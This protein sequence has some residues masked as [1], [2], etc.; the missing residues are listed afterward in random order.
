MSEPP[1]MSRWV[2]RLVLFALACAVPGAGVAGESGGTMT[3]RGRFLYTAA[4]ERVV[5]RGVNEMFAHSPDPTGQWTLPEIARTG[6]N[7][8]RIMTTPDYA[9]ETLDAVLRNAINNG[10]IPIAEC[11]AATGKWEKLGDC[12]DYW[13]RPDIAAVVRRHRRWVLVNIANEAGAEVSASAF[14]AGYRVAIARI[15][16]AD[17]DVPL[18]I[19]GSDWG[20]E[21]EML[22]DSWT[23]LNA[24]DPRRAILVSA[25]SYWVGTEQQR[26]APYRAIVKRVTRENIPFLLGEGPT[27]SGW[28]CGASPYR[29]AM[30]VL[31]RAQIGWLTWSWG[32]VPN[33]DCR[34]ENRYDVTNDGRYGHWK[35]DAGEA[36]MISDPGSVR[37]TS[38]RP[39]SIPNA[40]ASCT[41]PS[42]GRRRSFAEEA[43]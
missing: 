41:H 5:L 23:P 2:D 19:D 7:S 17:I 37:H 33:G 10:L 13:T 27:S 30:R 9:A 31:Q 38:R 43:Q 32:M 34:A 29:W 24:A 14:V 28:D 3:V 21:Y 25:H 11:H 20:K 15:R 12:V 26:K 6:A 35:S 42:G 36:L 16:A 8:V 22:L 18:V 4:G 39:C 40:G 1:P